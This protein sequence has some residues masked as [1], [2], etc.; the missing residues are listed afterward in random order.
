[1]SETSQGPGW[2]QAS[3]GKWYAP[4]LRP[5][6]PPPWGQ[7]PY[8]PPSS[9]RTNGLAIASL[10][11]S[12]TIFF[13]GPILAIIFG[14]IARR[15][16]RES[17]G[18]QGGD[19]LALAGLII[20]VVE[21]ALSLVVIAIV[22]VLIANGSFSHLGQQEVTISGAPGYSTFTGEH[23]LPLDQGNPWGHPCQPIVFQVGP[24]MPPQ[25]YDL[26]QQAVD[27]ARAAGVNVTLESRGLLWYPSL[28]Y[29]PGQTN[30][31]VQLVPI[32]PSTQA[33]PSLPDGHIEHISFGWDTR[34]AA[35]GEHE[36]LTDLQATLFLSAVRGDPQATQRA[37]RQLVAY[38]QGIGGSTSPGSSIAQ[39]N[40]ADAYSRRDIAAMQQMSGCTFQPTTLPRVP[41]TS[42]PN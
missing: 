29:P 26:I 37:V 24:T 32:F 16:I 40:T 10:V 36:V 19:G 20:G 22:A 8:T 21:L 30:S 42:T 41:P 3:D 31:T 15:Q 25:Q 23:G 7:I 34:I 33:P 12:L 6:P 4:E 2:W 39:G 11:L 17:S 1:M 27:G 35:D 28:L 18:A 9:P 13:V 38:S 14:I 5:S